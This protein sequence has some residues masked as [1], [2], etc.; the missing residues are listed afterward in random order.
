MQTMF[1]VCRFLFYRLPDPAAFSHLKNEI[2][3]K[4]YS[5]LFIILSF[6]IF[7]IFL[8]GTANHFMAVP[9]VH[10]MKEVFDCATVQ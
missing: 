2:C 6:S 9:R 7:I 8:T 10:L 4:K 5:R 3:M 1:F